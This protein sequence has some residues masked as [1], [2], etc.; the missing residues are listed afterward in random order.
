MC[1]LIKVLSRAKPPCSA[2]PRTKIYLATGSVDM[3]KQFDCL[4]TLAEDRMKADPR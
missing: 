2:F 4:W 1:M 3:R